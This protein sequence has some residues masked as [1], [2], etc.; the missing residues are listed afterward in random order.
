MNIYRQ[1]AEGGGYNLPFLVRITT[2][3]NATHITHI[4]RLFLW[5]EARLFVVSEKSVAQVTAIVFLT[6]LLFP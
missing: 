3:D 4:P 1:L 6:N 2:P 5:I